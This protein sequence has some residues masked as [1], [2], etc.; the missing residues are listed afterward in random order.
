MFDGIKSILVLEHEIIVSLSGNKHE[1]IRNKINPV[2]KRIIQKNE[3]YHT[4]LF[5]IL[6]YMS[7]FLENKH[8]PNPIDDYICMCCMP[9]FPFICCCTRSF[10]ELTVE[11][12]AAMSS[13]VRVS[14]LTGFFVF[15]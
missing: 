10:Y 13:W 5:N 15:F 9:V 12:N 1:L 2:Q 8:H 14:F 11:R 6:G 7:K 4:S 3:K